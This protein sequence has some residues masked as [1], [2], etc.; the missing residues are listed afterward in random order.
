MTQQIEKH[1]FKAEVNEV[2]SIVVNSLYS[3]K[4]IF[5]RELISNASDALDK[6]AF[7]SLTDHSLLGDDQE[8]RIDLIPN[9]A[10]G[11]LTIRDNGIG[12]NHDE[13]LNNL[14]T[15][16]KSGTKQLM[17]SLSAEQKKDISLIGQFGVGFYSAFLVADK[18]TVTSR[19]AGADE[20]WMWRSEAHGEF[21]LEPSEKEA[22]GTNIILHLKD[23]MK[24]FLQ[25]WEIR[26]LVRKY[27]DYVRHPIQLQV[28]KTKPVGEEK[29][30]DGNPKVTEQVKEWET[31]NSASALWTRPKAEITDEQYN[32]F[33]KHLSH[34]W[35]DPLTHTHFRVEG[36]QELTGLL[37]VPGRAPMDMMGQKS[38]GL[39]LY[40]KRVFIMEDCEEIL[41]EWL[42]FTQGVID[43][44]DLPLNVSREI[45]QK[46]QVTRGIRKQ[47]INKS[48]SM[49]SDMAKEG[50][51]TIKDE[52]GK[53]SKTNRYEQFWQQF[54]KILKE[55]M[56]YDPS[57]KDEI[58]QLCRFES[59]HGEGLSSLQD[60]VDRM[61]EDQEAIYYIIAESMETAKHSPHIEALRKK[62]FE[63]LFMADAVDEWVVQ[64][65]N[66][67]AG[68]KLVSAA[69]G[70]LDMP[71]TEEEKKQKEEKTTEFSGL[72][73]NVKKSLAQHVKE[74]R[75]TNR[76]TDSPACLVIDE[77]GIS[78]YLEKVLRANGQDVPEQKRILELNPE[79]PVVVRLQAMAADEG[80]ATEVEEWGELLFDQALVAEGNLPADPAKFAKAIS[81]LMQ[82]AVD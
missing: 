26:G 42:R 56:H 60:Y 23:D 80:K 47:V 66:E 2:L 70:S 58:A 77:N 57:H 13:L 6:L 76:L 27:S 3:H 7:Q 69:K 72:L 17:Q 46:E 20:A 39:R 53:E 10:S 59:S 49:L 4:E 11:T 31:I 74:V 12:M 51:V 63:I 54:G 15:I 73:E 19:A 32:D 67:F 68:K 25:D 1:T 79:H 5:L 45:L 82:K 8:M 75:L 37:F 21:T 41:P 61:P 33:Y 14:G 9:E 48:L 38:K 64:S 16:A 34:D 81:N 18:V 30:E 28:E 36:T 29:D 50:E 62:G 55:G 52:E 43:S 71:E 40:V 35:E 65:L 78:P 44:E 22:R 24:N